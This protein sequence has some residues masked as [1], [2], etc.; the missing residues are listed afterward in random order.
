[1]SCI[2]IDVCVIFHARILVIV[3]ITLH[4]PSIK[5][6]LNMIPLVCI[7]AVNKKLCCTIQ[8]EFLR[9]EICLNLVLLGFFLPCCVNLGPVV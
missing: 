7:P 6:S 1:M 2:V 5:L 3:S 4:H 8:L 9:L